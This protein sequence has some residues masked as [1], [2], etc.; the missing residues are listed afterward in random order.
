M[1]IRI[2]T[3]QS[4]GRSLNFRQRFH[5]I[6]Y[7]AGDRSLRHNGLL[8]LD[9][10]ELQAL[11]TRLLEAQPLLSTLAR[12]QSIRGLFEVLGLAV[13]ALGTPDAQPQQIARVL[14]RIA[15]VIEA[16]NGERPHSLSVWSVD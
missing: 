8:Y 10:K 4:W 13:D 15:A 1:G 9:A 7:P 6:F 16:T 12:D 5:H 2:S 14:A 11:A 3:N